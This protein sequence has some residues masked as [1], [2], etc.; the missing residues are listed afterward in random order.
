MRNHVQ[1]IKTDVSPWLRTARRHATT[2]PGLSELPL[3]FAPI[4]TAK[5]VGTLTRRC[6]TMWRFNTVPFST[7]GVKI[8]KSNECSPRQ[9][10]RKY[11]ISFGIKPYRGGLCSLTAYLPETGTERD[12][13]SGSIQKHHPLT[14]NESSIPEYSWVFHPSLLAQIYSQTPRLRATGN[15]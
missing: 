12:A 2:L 5:E 10:K 8:S 15:L 13:L 3:L 6:K 14:P 9:R 7:A 1:A 4:R 11:E